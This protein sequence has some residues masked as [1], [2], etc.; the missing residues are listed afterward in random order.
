MNA[1]QIT[2]ARQNKLP[3]L[4]C[5]PGEKPIECAYIKDVNRFRSPSSGKIILS[6]VLQ[7]AN[8]PH[9]DIR[10]RSRYIKLKEDVSDETLKTS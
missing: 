1:R 4:C 2:Y 6:C 10:V 9:S 7:D 3:V 5:L 8:C